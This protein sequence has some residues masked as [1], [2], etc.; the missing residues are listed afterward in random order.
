MHPLEGDLPVPHLPVRVARGALVSHT[1][2]ILMRL[3]AAQPR[4]DAG[5]LFSSQRTCRT[6][7]QPLYSM[8]WH[9]RV[10]KVERMFFLF[11]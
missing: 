6:I 7:L 11:P 9:W 5:P 8:V 1:V 3:L 2:G 4:G 10:S